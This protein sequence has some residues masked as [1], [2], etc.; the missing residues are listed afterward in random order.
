[1]PILAISSQ[2]SGTLIWALITVGLPQLTDDH[3]SLLICFS[4][5]IDIQ[6]RCSRFV[7]PVR[8]IQCCSDSSDLYL[9]SADGTGM[10]NELDQQPIVCSKRFCTYTQTLYVLMMLSL[11][12][13]SAS[14]DVVKWLSETS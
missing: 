10:K 3:F 4:H 6:T 11:E 5:L 8:Y 13:R 2:C 9:Q 12:L 1:M 14:T 7:L